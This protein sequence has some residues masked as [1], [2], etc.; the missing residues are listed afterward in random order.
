M[1][2]LRNNVTWNSAVSP[3]TRDCAYCVYDAMVTPRNRGKRKMRDDAS[4][5]AYVQEGFRKLGLLSTGN[6]TPAVPEVPAVPADPS[7]PSSSE[8]RIKIVVG[9]SSR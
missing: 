6:H 8:P 5:T 2:T 1:S 7:Q 9:D 4:V 3:A